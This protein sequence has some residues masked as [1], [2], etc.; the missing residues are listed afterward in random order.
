MNSIDFQ[1][2]ILAAGFGT[3]LGEYGEHLPKGLIPAGNTT[4]LGHVLAELSKTGITD[5]TLVTNAKYATVYELYLDQMAE[6]VEL[7]NNGITAPEFRSGVLGDLRWVIEQKG[8][9]KQ[10]ILVLPSDTY[11]EFSLI[12][13]IS[14][15]SQHPH[16]FAAV[17]KSGPVDQIA[18]RLGCGVINEAGQ[19]IDFVEKPDEPLSP[20][21][22]IPF[23]YYPPLALQALL[24]YEAEGNSMDA[25]GSILPWLIQHGQTV[26]A[27]I[28]DGRTI[29]VGTMNKVKLLESHQHGS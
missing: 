19:L 23:Y 22:A 28:A 18:H 20:Y 3:R 9:Q 24:E 1:V 8:W 25:P 14:F 7:I 6:S 10:A 26:H 11:F 29:D 27:Y 4:L 12:E 16:D 5:V 13:F 2:V 21:A 17:F 15:I